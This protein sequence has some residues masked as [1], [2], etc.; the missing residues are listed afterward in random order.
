MEIAVIGIG[1][2]L[3]PVK[4]GGPNTCGP[5]QFWEA[6]KNERDITPFPAKTPQT[7]RDVSGCL[8]LTDVDKFD[9]EFFGVSERE[10]QLMDPRHR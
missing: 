1:S 9:A 7:I 2:R 6:L 5:S 8:A 3:P 4:P 10:A